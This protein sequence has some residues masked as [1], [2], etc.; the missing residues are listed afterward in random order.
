M[1]PWAYRQVINRM[2]LKAQENRVCLVKVPP[3][4]TSRTCPA[5]GGV[6]KKNRV[7]EEFVCIGCGY[8]ADADFVGAQN[9][10]AWTTA[11]LGSVKSPRLL[12]SKQHS[13]AY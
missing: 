9:V 11:A 8:T 3:A 12:E 1:A 4:N 7:G 5:C 6:S 2:E 10:L 13:T